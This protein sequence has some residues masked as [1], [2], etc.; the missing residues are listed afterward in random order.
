MCNTWPL[1]RVTTG[2][3]TFSLPLVIELTCS[4]F[5]LGTPAPG[6]TYAF[7]QRS[8][9]RASR[10]FIGP[11]L[12][13]TRPCENSHTFSHSAERRSGSVA[14]PSKLHCFRSRHC[15]CGRPSIQ[16]GA[17]NAHNKRRF[18]ASRVVRSMRASARSSTKLRSA[19]VF[20][21]AGYVASCARKASAPRTPSRPRA[22]WA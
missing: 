21:Q 7:S 17:H 12:K 9:S 3:K 18:N 11:T 13:G 16:R 2:F 22:R 14:P 15:D 5:G 10:P 8:L 20:R 1:K 6:A 4:K 19:S